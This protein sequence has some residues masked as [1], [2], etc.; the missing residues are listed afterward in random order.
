MKNAQYWIDSLNL[1]PH[2]EGGYFKESIRQPSTETNRAAFSSI[3]FLLTP[4]D[5]SHFHRIDADE[6]W[7]YHD[8]Q[9]LTIHMIT[10]DG[11]YESVQLGPNIED[12]EVM[13]YTVPKRTIFASSLEHDEGFCLVGCMC[14]PAFEYEQFELFERNELNQM[15]PEHQTVIDK[16]ALKHK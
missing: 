10:P 11:K 12:G 5:I 3:Y 14:Q 6:V 4:S 13:Q 1:T 7:Y 8:G 16:Y 2:P 15:Y 9:S